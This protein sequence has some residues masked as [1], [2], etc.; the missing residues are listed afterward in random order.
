MVYLKTDGIHRGNGTNE[1]C[2]NIPGTNTLYVLK[3]ILQRIPT[4]RKEKTANKTVGA[5]PSRC[6]S[7]NRLNPPIQ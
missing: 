5:Y 2:K 6:N 4:K 7:T 3:L 1:R